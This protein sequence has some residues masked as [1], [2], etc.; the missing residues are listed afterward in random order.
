MA[1]ISAFTH[2]FLHRL[3]TRLLLIPASLCQRCSS[4][5]RFVGSP[6]P[7]NQRSSDLLPILGAR[8]RSWVAHTAVAE[9]PH[10]GEVPTHDGGV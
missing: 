4:P 7:R 5:Q 3:L 10:A 6:L 8:G 9:V 1:Q 2:K